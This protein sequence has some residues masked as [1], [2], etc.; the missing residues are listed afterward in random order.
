[1]SERIVKTEVTTTS[2]SSK[3]ARAKR[4]QR[5]RKLT[6]MSRKKFAD[7]YKISQ[8]TLQNWETAR[9]GG[10][11]EKGAQKILEAL[12][13]ENIYCTFQWL[14]YN[15][16]IGPQ[17]ALATNVADL[18]KLSNI[19]STEKAKINPLATKI[20]FEAFM[21]SHLNVIHTTINDDYMMPF[22]SP[23]EL[24]AGESVTGAKIS[25][26]IDKIC[27]IDTKEHG[28]LVRRLRAGG[29]NFYTLI[30]TNTDSKIE[31]PVLYNVEINSAAL[32][33]WARKEDSIT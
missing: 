14:M 27:I 9:F 23:G 10:L 13:K 4:L 26:L 29:E 8:G 28:T 22:F 3:Q 1:M 18:T 21:S 24:V 31:K 19:S 15:E 20:E 16:G 17:K 12:K 33:T 2:S 30:A 5:L 6:E 7:T 32:V 11:T 25:Q